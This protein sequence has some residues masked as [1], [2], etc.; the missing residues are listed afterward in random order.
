MK[1]QLWVFPLSLA[2]DPE[3]LHSN[4]KVISE[5]GVAGLTFSGHK[6]NM[7]NSMTISYLVPKTFLASG[8]IYSYAAH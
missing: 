2:A 1:K 8:R 6:V 4:G 5:H 3:S 7:I